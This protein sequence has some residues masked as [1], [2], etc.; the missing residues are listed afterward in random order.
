MET[1]FVRPNEANA[2]RLSNSE[3]ETDWSGPVVTRTGQSIL[4]TPARPDDREALVRFFEKVASEDLYYRFL[5]GMKHVDAER[6]DSMVRDDD[7][8]SIDF[9]AL[10]MET[11]EILASAMLV[12]DETFDTIEFALCTREDMKRRGISWAL[13]DHAARYAEAMG[14]RRIQSIESYDQADALQLE[15]EMGF[16]LLSCPDDAALMLTEKVF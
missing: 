3:A 11:G 1:N 16:K 10:E 8:R 13:L 7:D 9:L 6:I 14:A 12:A 15:R 2:R 5:S 4:I